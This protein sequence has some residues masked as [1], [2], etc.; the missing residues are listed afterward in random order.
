MTV[1]AIQQAVSQL[2]GHIGPT[3]FTGV[4]YALVLTGLVL[5][6][7]IIVIGSAVLI[8]R[9]VKA[10]GNMTPSRFVAALI[11]VAVAFIIAGALFP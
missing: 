10:M 2:F 11:A 9:G 7:G 8:A 5:L 6:L 4:G 3:N 1:E